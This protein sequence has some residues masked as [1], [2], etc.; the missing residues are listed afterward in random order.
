MSSHTKDSRR[1]RRLAA[2]I[3]AGAV[4]ATGVGIGVA[5]AITP[6]GSPT[7][8][9]VDRPEPGDS[10]DT[11]A[12]PGQADRP[13]PGDTPDSTGVAGQPDQAEPGDVADSQG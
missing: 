13:E 7:S 11:S 2:G 6:Q 9:S 1:V 8:T 5:N 10:P 4:L 3:A 12:T